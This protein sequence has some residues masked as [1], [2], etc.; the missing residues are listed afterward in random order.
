M[1]IASDPAPPVAAEQARTSAHPRPWLML[2]H[3]LPARPSNLRVRTW[4]RLQQIGAVAVRQAVYVLPDGPSAREDFEWLK[5]EITAAGGHAS[6]FSAAAVDTSTND[7]LVKEFRRSRQDAYETLAREATQWL[8]RL[9]AAPRRRPRAI[10]FKRK[11]EQLRE[12]LAAVE[13]IDFFGSTGRDRVLGLLQQVEERVRP[14][15][16]QPDAAV[17]LKIPQAYIERLWVTRPRPGID[18]V[19]SAWLIKRFVDAKAR[20]G[21]VADRTA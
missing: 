6:V 2:V 13:R 1:T 20:F 18:R 19:A 12:R 10:L 9:S 3:H 11:L 4:R 8:R 16:S 5:T 14:P 7:A 15:R 21:F 17:G